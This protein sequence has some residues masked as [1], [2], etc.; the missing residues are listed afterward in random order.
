MSG[1]ADAFSSKIDGAR[2]S[3]RKT[4]MPI[5]EI[6]T[7]TLGELIDAVT[8]REPDAITGHHRDRGIY[9]GVRHVERPLL[10]SLDQLGGIDPPH[11]KADLEEHLLRT[12]ARYSRPYL[13]SPV[14]NEWELLVHAQHHGLPTRLLDWSYS[15]LIAAHFATIDDLRGGDRVIWRLDWHVVHRRFS[16]PMLAR[17]TQDVGKAVAD[18]EPI[19]P[20][21]L[22]NGS[23]PREFACMV[24]P[25]SVHPRIQA[26]GAV[27]TIC[28]DKT[29]SFDAFLFRHG[30]GD[31]L[32]R[33]V[34]PTS[35]V[36]HVRDQLDLAGIDERLL[37]PDLDG[38][39]AR[40]RRYYS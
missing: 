30:I 21:D 3:D 28:S 39:A 38:V 19:T 13:A 2:G 7:S 17:S 31:A 9:R 15:P 5:V 37:Y 10:T 22:M 1:A 6:T 18:D 29:Q 33:L 11:T 8:P 36:R 12:F 23:M 26:Q 20:W 35:S 27:F 16:I 24:D 34:I 25:P 14:E 32:M 40:I 4:R